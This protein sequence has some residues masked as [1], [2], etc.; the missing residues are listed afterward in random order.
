[1]SCCDENTARVP[2]I[3]V[4]RR[5]LFKGA[6][7]VASVIPAVRPDHA[8]AQQKQVK[9][10]FCSQLLCIIPY[11]V[12]R[13][14]ASSESKGSRSSSSICAAAMR[15]CRRWSA[16]RSITPPPRSTWRSR[17]MRMA[18]RSAASPRPASCRSSRSRRRRNRRD[19]IN[20]LKDLEG[21]TVGVSALGNAD[22]ALDALSAEESRR[23]CGQGA[24]RDH[25]HQSARSAAPGPAR[26]RAGAGAGADAH[27]SAPAARCW[28]MRCR[29][30]TRSTISAAI[31]SSWASPCARR[32]SSSAR[33]DGGARPRAAGA[34]GR[35][36]ESDAPTISSKRC[37]GD[38]D[39]RRSQRDARHLGQVP[40]LALSR[41]A[42]R[43][44]STAAGRV[45]QVA[46]GRRSAQARHRTSPVSSTLRS[47]EAE[48]C[49]S[50]S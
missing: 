37:R 28:S 7:F 34:L 2:G 41:P 27:R 5:S 24:V 48:C 31:T 9:L 10:A 16:A 14:R 49:A 50:T 39:R 29:P 38:D 33:R 25:R 13:A 36:A 18:R 21:R 44:I 26:C 30:P 3:K 4:S 40:R 35:G 47:P 46:E 8:N 6:A 20:A 11:E 45:A 42:S 17:P 15:R 43:S 19:K 22:H 1:M 23:R 12:A 32:A